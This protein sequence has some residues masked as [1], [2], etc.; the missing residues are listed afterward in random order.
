[1]VPAVSQDAVVERVLQSRDNSEE[2]S[3]VTFPQEANDA[4]SEPNR[5]KEHENGPRRMSQMLTPA[6]AA[7]VIGMWGHKNEL[8][9]QRYSQAIRGMPAFRITKIKDN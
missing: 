2:G 1:M 7:G 8:L 6:M 5:Q 3:L 9:A 4:E